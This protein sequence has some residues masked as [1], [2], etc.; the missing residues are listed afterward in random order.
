MKTSQILTVLNMLLSEVEVNNMT[1]F[2]KCALYYMVGEIYGK[3]GMDL[4]DSVV[5]CHGDHFR[6][7]E[8]G[9]GV[10]ARLSTLPTRN[11]IL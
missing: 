9:N 11:N 8:T 4:L 7:T 6:I 3:A 5:V 1:S 10:F 2:A